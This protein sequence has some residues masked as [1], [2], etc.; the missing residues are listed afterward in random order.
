MKAKVYTQQGKEKGSVELPEGIFGLPWNGDLVHQVAISMA[1][2]ARIPYAH[3]KDRSDVSG[4][5]RKP[6]RQKGT[7]R[8]RHGSRRSPIWRT[9]GVTFGP[10]NERVFAKS[11]NRKMRQKALLTLLSRKFNE[12]N[13]LFVDALSLPEVKT[14]EA[15]KVLDALSGVSDSYNFAGKKKNSVCIY[16]PERD[17]ALL[18]AFANLGNVEVMDHTQ[19]NP[20]DLARF[21]YSVIVDPEKAIAFLETKKISSKVPEKTKASAGKTS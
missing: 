11:I 3:T 20:L 12:G 9:G 8:A 14:S 6:W 4:G 18:R 16:L 21:A 10:R 1:A 19:M 5:G 7:G 13:V 15:K 17:E 2:N